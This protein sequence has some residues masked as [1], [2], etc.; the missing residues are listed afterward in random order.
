[1][2]I[3]FVEVVVEERSVKIYVHNVT[4]A[5]SESSERISVG[6]MC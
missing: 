5:L 1:M 3:V 6:V 2:C 4:E